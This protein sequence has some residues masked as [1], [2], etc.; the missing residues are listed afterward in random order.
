MRG[1]YRRPPPPPGPLLLFL[2]AGSEIAG[3]LAVGRPR[4]DFDRIGMIVTIRAAHG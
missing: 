1:R 2:P 3:R 4:G